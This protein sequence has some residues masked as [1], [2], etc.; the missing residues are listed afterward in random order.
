MPR[1]EDWFVREL[2]NIDPELEVEWYDCR[3]N[4][5]GRHLGCPRSWDRT[6]LCD[7]YVIWR[8][9]SRG[10][11][12]VDRFARRFFGTEPPYPERIDLIK[13]PPDALDRRALRAIQKGIR[14]FE[15]ITGDVVGKIRD[16]LIEEYERVKKE[17]ERERK[18]FWEEQTDGYLRFVRDAG[19]DVG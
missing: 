12:A 4:G 6:K 13:L 17:T 15:S 10:G 11:I 7:R 16:L 14:Q 19:C 3:D 8:R 5:T 9:I 18:Q 2:K 1:P